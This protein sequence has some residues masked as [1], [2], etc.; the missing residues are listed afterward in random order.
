MLDK[1]EGYNPREDPKRIEAFNALMRTSFPHF[2]QRVFKQMSPATE[3]LPNWHIDLMGEY[4]AAVTRGELRRL[5][6]NIPPRYAKSLIVS[7][8]WPAH[9]LGHKP[10]TQFLAA[11]YSDKLANEFNVKTRDVM[12]SEWY[13]RAFPDV[14]L[15]PDQNEKGYFKTTVNGHRFA[16][17][18]GASSIGFGGDIIIVDDPLSPKKAAS[19]VERESANDWF[20]QS[21]YTRMNNKKTAAIVLVMQRLHQTDLTGH[22]IEKGGWEHLNIPAIAEKKTIISYG[23]VSVV[24]E[25]GDLLHEAREGS[26]EIQEAKISLG[27][28][29]FSAQYQQNPTPADGDI[30]KLDWFREYRE[31]PVFIRII[32][33][34]DTA[35]KAEMLNDP[36]VC[37]TW[38]ETLNGY[39]LLDV[40]RRRLIYPDLKRNVMALVAKYAPSVILIED[41]ASGQSL[42]Q[43]LK[44]E[45]ALPVI[46]ITPEDDK[47]TRAS[48]VSP[49]VE[50][51]RIYIPKHAQ[52]VHDYLTE[53]TTFP[54]AENDDQVDSTTQML[55]WVKT[56]KSKIH[57]GSL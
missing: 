29:G 54:N 5:I 4:L 33:S 14:Q 34:W 25:P 47:L 49:L 27:T 24:R 36:S 46:A 10:S 7:T 2:F 48:V 55:N 45:S 53:M 57:M 8:A 39:Y 15:A 18:V 26:A 20:D 13:R 12:Q 31:P 1:P 17:S 9:V 42:I 3:F 44:G 35:Y 11:S 6:I 19:K 41:K 51:G 22:L 23:K 43:D 40:F 16:T 37:T 52:W 30:F 32:Q 56:P 28:A 38:G 50:S 21:L